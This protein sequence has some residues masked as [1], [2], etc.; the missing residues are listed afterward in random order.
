MV[1]TAIEGTLNVL[2]AANKC[3]DVRKIVL[4]S[5]VAAIDGKYDWK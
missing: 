3:A 2:R 4:T 5:S 1:R